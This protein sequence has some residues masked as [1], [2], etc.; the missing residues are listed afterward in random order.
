MDLP[1]GLQHSHIGLAGLAMLLFSAVYFKRTRDRAEKARAAA[2]AEAQR[3]AAISAHEVRLERYD[4]LWLAS[5]TA[6]S[7]ERRILAVK[8]GLP[9]CPQCVKPLTSSQGI[10][11]WKCPSCGAA[12]ADTLGTL[13]VTDAIT[14]EAL[15]MFRKA[16]EDYLGP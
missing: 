9:Y 3:Q 5:V 10:T 14:R 7:L 4:A 8:P 13:T 2:E 12:F 16:H 15:E 11:P 6:S 1:Y